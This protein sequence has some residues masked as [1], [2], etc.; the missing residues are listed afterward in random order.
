[1]EDT[2]ND[3]KHEEGSKTEEDDAQVSRSEELLLDTK[4]KKEGSSLEDT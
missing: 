2:D 3:K 1:M 4:E